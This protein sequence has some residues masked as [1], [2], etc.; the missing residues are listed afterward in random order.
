MDL[1]NIE[2][3]SRDQY[4]KWSQLKVEEVKDHPAS[5]SLA[6]KEGLDSRTI[7]YDS[8]SFLKGLIGQWSFMLSNE[9]GLNPGL[10]EEV[11]RNLAIYQEI[12]KA[13]RTYEE[14]YDRASNQYGEIEKNLP[15]RERST[16]KLAQKYLETKEALDKQLM[17]N[18]ES[19]IRELLISGVTF[20]K[21]PKIDWLPFYSRYAN[22]VLKDPILLFDYIQDN[23]VWMELI[24]N[25]VTHEA[26]IINIANKYGEKT[27]EY[28]ITF[29]NNI[30]EKKSNRDDPFDVVRLQ[31]IDLILTMLPQFGRWWT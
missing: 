17:E 21:A 13:G 23:L 10:S 5:S 29:I 11:Q 8:D 3:S 12:E 7:D 25:T 28:A 18:R 19:F 2:K 9:K 20:D 16:A 15:R 14:D 4:E 6:R 1:E 26:G 22:K 30:S 27:S 24:Q 31:K